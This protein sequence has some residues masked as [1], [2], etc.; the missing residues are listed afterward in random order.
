MS[1]GSRRPVT[2]SITREDLIERRKKSIQH[3]HLHTIFE[4]PNEQYLNRYPDT[5][6][7]ICYPLTTGEQSR[8]YRRVEQLV[9]T[10]DP[11]LT[12]SR[13]NQ[14]SYYNTRHNCTQRSFAVFLQTLT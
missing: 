10:F 7:P 9:K 4:Q 11:N 14:Q 12:L 3:R 6:C 1:S 2:R 5:S 13:I 8:G